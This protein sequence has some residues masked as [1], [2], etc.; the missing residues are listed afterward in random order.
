MRARR[1]LWSGIRT[2]LRQILFNLLNNAIKFTDHGGVR[3]RAGTLPLGGGSTCATVA[4]T[5]TGIG[6][7]AE[8]LARFNRSYRPI[9]RPHGNSEGRGLAFPSSG[10]SRRPW[11]VMLPSRARRA[12]A[13]P[14]PSR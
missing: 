13:L 3:V 2:G 9:A 11:A 8:Q 4:V 7:D 5:D 12:A 10:G 6:L 1:T 14:S